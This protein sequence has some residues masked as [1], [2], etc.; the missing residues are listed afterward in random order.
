M[1]T[2]HPP[3][4]ADEALEREETDDFLAL[5]RSRPIAHTS[6]T[7]SSESAASS[8]K[9]KPPCA[10]PAV[11]SEVLAFLLLGRALPPLRSESRLQQ[12]PNR[13]L[14]PDPYNNLD[15]YKIL[16]YCPNLDPHNNRDPNLDLNLDPNLNPNFDL[17]LDSHNILAY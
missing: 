6:G 8:F 5:S 2:I 17:N 7:S 9:F 14:N 12:E 11:V 13:E 1:S 15:L 3:A 4:A 16:D 10:E